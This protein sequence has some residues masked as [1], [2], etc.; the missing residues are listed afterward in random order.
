MVLPV[1]VVDA[2]QAFPKN[3]PNQRIA[4]RAHPL[5]ESRHGVL[6]SINQ[7][8]YGGAVTCM[9]ITDEFDVCMLM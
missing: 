3:G 8:E 7:F 1:S 9:K 6:Q 4:C 5:P 2:S